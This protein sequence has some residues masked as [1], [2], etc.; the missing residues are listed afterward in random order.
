MILE[1]LSPEKT[2]YR[3]EVESVTL[4]GTIGSFQVLRNHAPLISSL[5]RGTLTF[6]VKGDLQSMK[7]EEGFVEV[8]D[9]KIIVCIDSVKK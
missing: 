7:V 9:N 1:I 3:G 8:S 2:Y 6:A 4:P 5:R